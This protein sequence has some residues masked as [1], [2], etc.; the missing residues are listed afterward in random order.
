MKKKNT[1][2]EDIALLIILLINF[3]NEKT[4]IL[5]IAQSVIKIIAQS[6]LQRILDMLK[7]IKLRF[8]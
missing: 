5:D 6:G 8:F 1:L 2:L 7:Y 4:K 3:L